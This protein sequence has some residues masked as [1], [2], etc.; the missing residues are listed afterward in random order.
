MMRRLFLDR[1]ASSAAEFGLVLPLL[2]FFLFG[3]IDSGRFLWE[4]NKA[5]KAT[6]AGARVIVVTDSAS[7]GLAAHSY[8]GDTSGGAALTQG[9]LVPAAALGEARCTSSGGTVSCTCV[10][11]PCPT[12]TP[13]IDTGFDQMLTRMQF[14]KS[15][16]AE[17]NVS[18]TYRG[19]GLGFAGDPNGMDIAPLVTVELSGLQFRPLVL[20]NSV[21]FDL[22]AFRTTLTSE[23]SSGSVSN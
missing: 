21:V 20:F 12:L 17:Q 10:T 23:D 15:D 16:I 22:P 4:I 7:G 11:A 9:D 14:M 19:S 3:I 18:V 5:E 8:L 6:Q 2:I 1:K 13:Y